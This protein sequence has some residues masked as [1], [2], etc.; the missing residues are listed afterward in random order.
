MR[1]FRIISVAA[2]ALVAVSGVAAEAPLQVVFVLF[3]APTQFLLAEGDLDVAYT[4]LQLPAHGMLVG[5]AP[6]LTYTPNPGFSGT[7]WVHYLVQT[8]TGQWDFG[9]VQLVVLAPGVTMSPFVFTSEGELVWSGAAVVPERYR[10]VFGI[11]ARFTY[12][13]QV[14]RA[15]WTDVGFTS[16]VG[17]TRIEFEGT[18][19]SPWRLPI[20]STLD[21]DP[22]VPGLR[23]WT[24][25]ART[26][27][28]GATWI[29]RFFF[30]GTAPQTGSYATF[31]VQGTVG[32]FT[33]DNTLKYVTLTPT[34]GE[35]RLILK[36]PWI[37]E[38]CPTNWELEF[39]QTKAGFD[40]LS[41]LV[42]DV[43]I[44]CPG[45]GGIQTF[46]DVEITYT[47]DTKTVEPALRVVSDW[48]ACVRPFV[49]LL[50]PTGGLGIEG[51]DL[52]G[53]EIRCEIPGGYTLRL[54]TSF[55]PLRDSA[56][57][58]YAQFFE[59]W[60]VEGPVVPCCGSPG[61]FQLSTY[62]QRAGGTLFGFGMANMILH[63]PLSREVL[64]NVGLM[65]G[66]VDPLDPTKRW[67]L[68]TGWRAIF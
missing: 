57:T 22:T 47:V 66:D 42:K 59:L 25:D 38:G 7:D 54:A 56:V 34:F 48:V 45:C 13:E 60:Q 11:Q 46:F 31:Q 21:F 55:N 4:I 24:V 3:D 14:L 28:L 49:S 40:H 16:F 26:T 2:L 52:F 15:T 1:A 27:A 20:T 8:G 9:T 51:V 32:A 58:G 6:H 18:W 10:F 5:I 39:L 43:E 30:S 64:I 53:F 61:R 19:P 36:G 68:T 12:F 63:F 33:F 17:T 29:Y 41:F 35:N 65:I 67:I 37:C 50:T 23:S 44:P 62:F